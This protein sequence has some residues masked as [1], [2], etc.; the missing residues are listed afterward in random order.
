[1]KDASPEE[2]QVDE[3]WLH[4]HRYAVALLVGF[5]IAGMIGAPMVFPEVQLWRTLIGGALLGVFCSFCVA[6]PR[7]LE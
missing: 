2:P 5:V 1:M 4:A 7:F 6:L 3:S